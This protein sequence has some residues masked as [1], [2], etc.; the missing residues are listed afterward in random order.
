MTNECAFKT[1]QECRSNGYHVLAVSDQVSS[2]SSGS[3]RR[4]V[5]AESVSVCFIGAN[6]S[7]SGEERVGIVER[8]KADRCKLL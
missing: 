8:D 6:G 2:V 7:R 1:F 3:D 4:L 5:D